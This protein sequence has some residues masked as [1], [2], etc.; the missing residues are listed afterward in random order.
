M[1]VSRVV[2]YLPAD[3]VAPVR[4]FYVGVLGFTAGFDD[5][6]RIAVTDAGEPS[7]SEVFILTHEIAP[8]A[9]IPRMLVEVD[10][11]DE[12][13]ARAVAGG[14]RIVYPLTVEPWGVRRFFV[15]DPGGAVINVLGS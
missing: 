14:H 1:T 7:R 5:L 9:P 15:E 6:P 8:G 3:P 13:F 12:T 2:P 4:D 11:L 10:D